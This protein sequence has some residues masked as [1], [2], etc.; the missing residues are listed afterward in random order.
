MATVVINRKKIEQK[1]DILKRKGK[2]NLTD[3]K[4]NT[5]LMSASNLTN[6]QQN[7][8]NRLLDKNFKT[9][10]TYHENLVGANAFPVFLL[11]ISLFSLISQ[12]L[13]LALKRLKQPKVVCNVLVCNHA[14]CILQSDI[15]IF[16]CN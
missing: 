8:Q 1:Q 15:L 4:P 12:L 7:F 14:S 2:K 16:I 5:R 9:C 11:Q 13:H 6:H 10:V 3:S